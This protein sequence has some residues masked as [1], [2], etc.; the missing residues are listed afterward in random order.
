MKQLSILAGGFEHKRAEL[1][2]LLDEWRL[3]DGHYREG[4]P[5]EE[6]RRRNEELN[7][8]YDKINELKQINRAERWI[9]E[10]EEEA[11]PIVG[12]SAKASLLENYLNNCSDGQYTN[13]AIELSDFDIPGAIRKDLFERSDG[14]Q[15]TVVPIPGIAAYPVYVPTL[16]DRLRIVPTAQSAVD[17]YSE[18]VWSNVAAPTAEGGTVPEADF[19]LTR[20][21]ASVQR[22]GAWIPATR[23]QLEDVPESRR[24]LEER[25]ILAVRQ[26]LEDQIL[27]GTGTSPQLTGILSLSDINTRAL[28]TDPI[29][30]AFLD[31][32]ARCEG[33]G[34]TPGFAVADL[35]VVHST[36]WVTI[37]GQTDVNGN[38]ILGNPG[39]MTEPR[40]WGLPV[41]KSNMLTAGTGL[42][43]SFAN[44]HALYMRRGATVEFTDSHSDYFVKDIMALK[45]TVRA[46]SVVFRPRAFCKV[47]GL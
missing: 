21:T 12:K 2:S 29:M 7:E 27:N 18:S 42:V 1:K 37:A 35:I 31:A 8:L 30:T 3:P 11:K 32:I 33:S 15:P 26:K 25:L 40:L 17:Y 13:K 19:G 28:G 34:S 41:I 16:L 14:W 22:I 6:I 5:I 24:Y 4:V 9:T 38:Y 20:L 10:Q 45:C 44:Y 47:T 36:D 43:G 46:A 39:M 23:E